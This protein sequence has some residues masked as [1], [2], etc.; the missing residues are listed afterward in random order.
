[1]CRQVWFLPDERVLE[2][3][4]RRMRLRKKRSYRLANENEDEPP[5]DTREWAVWMANREQIGRPDDEIWDVG[6]LS[7]GDDDDDEQLHK[8][9]EGFIDFDSENGVELTKTTSIWDKK[10]DDDMVLEYGEGTELEDVIHDG[11]LFDH[12]DDGQS[13]VREANKFFEGKDIGKKKVGE[14]V[15]KKKESREKSVDKTFEKAKV[16]VKSDSETSVFD[17]DTSPPNKESAQEDDLFVMQQPKGE[18]NN[19]D[20]AFL[21]DSLPAYPSSPTQG[22]NGTT[23]T[24]TNDSNETT[25]KQQQRRKPRKEPNTK[26]FSNSI[27]VEDRKYDEETDILG[28]F[29]D[30]EP[31]P[32]DLEEMSRI[33]EK[34]NNNM[35]EAKLY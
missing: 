10:N 22:G 28:L 24:T 17:K 20:G 19:D 31:P 14:V 30:D 21:L 7:D 8:Q 33:E 5:L 11:R 3:R 1:M 15:Q 27:V 18:S 13:V 32:L 4:M 35:K 25:N 2:A 16:T 6:D 26:G 23:T 12:V 9:D 29:S 34:L